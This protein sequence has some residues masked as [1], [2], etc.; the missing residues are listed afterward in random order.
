MAA[1]IE[2]LNDLFAALFRPAEG[3]PAIRQPQRPLRED[4]FA[5]FFPDALVKPYADKSKSNLTWFFNHDP[6]NKSVRRSLAALLEADLPGTVADTHRKCHAALWP[7][8]GQ[9]AF[10]GALL[11]S[12][13]LSVRLPAGVESRWQTC[14][15]ATWAATAPSWGRTPRWPGPCATPGCWICRGG[16]RR[17]SRPS[18]GW[19]SS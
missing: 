6:R 2:T 19:R 1:H 9:P 11:K 15:G 8:A 10:D 12:V 14:G 13:L 16:T 7:R 4:L 17:P 5:L 3:A 18:S